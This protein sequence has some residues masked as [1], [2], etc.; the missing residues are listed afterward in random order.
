LTTPTHH[1]SVGK[2]VYVARCKR[3]LTR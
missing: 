3:L 2:Y 1:V